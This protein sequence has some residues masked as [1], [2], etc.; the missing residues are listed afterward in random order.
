ML[1][2]APVLGGTPKLLARDV[3]AHPA[4]SPDGQRMIYVRCNNPEAGKCRWLSANPDGSSEQMLLVRAASIPVGLSW[5]ADGK[6]IAFVLANASNL[7]QGKVQLFD[8]QK[9]QEVPLVS[10]PDKRFAD[11]K[12]L[13]DGR[14]LLALYSDRSTNY[15]RRQIGYLSYPDG[16]LEAVTNDTN[17]YNSV[18]LS[19]DGRTLSTIQNQ[20]V[21]EIDLLPASGGATASAVPGISKLLQQTRD[22]GWLNNSEIL[23]VLPSRMLKISLDG[24]QQTEIF[25]DSN[26]SLGSSAICE[27]GHTIVFTMRGHENDNADRLWRM[28]ADGSNLK[29]LTSGENDFLPQ[30]APAGK[31]VYYFGGSVPWMR[32][33]LQGG[34][35]EQ[36]KRP[37]AAD[38]GFPITG[39]SRDEQRFVAYSTHLETATN[40]YNRR[41]GIFNAA[42][43]DSPALSL[44]PDSRLKVVGLGIRFAPGG[45]LAYVITDDKNVDNIWLQPL[46]EKP[47]RQITQFQSD[48]IFGFAWSP[49]QKK[50]NVAR[51]HTESDVILLRDTSK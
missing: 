29:R 4:F 35:A 14:G 12:W 30:C 38:W 8:V 23:L 15:S 48:S 36:V 49:D 11:I 39:V 13:P 32:I 37:S 22:G 5:S 41:L 9:N 24:S 31:W 2:R 51:G 40:T 10:F 25:N 19:G 33:P 1:F 16:K 47:G 42:Q 50:F 46:D 20:P 18:A 44:V 34:T 21:A 43:T 6:F 3:D 17:N 27:N 7:D 28:D 45:Q 26:A